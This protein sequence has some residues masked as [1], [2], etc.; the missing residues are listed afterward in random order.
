MVKVV[1]KKFVVLYNQGDDKKFLYQSN[2][3]LDNCHFKLVRLGK[4]PPNNNLI[5]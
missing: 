2:L 3:S 4:L 5:I 1:P